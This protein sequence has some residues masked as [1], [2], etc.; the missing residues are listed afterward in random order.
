MARRYDKDRAATLMAY[1]GDDLGLRLGSVALRA[2][3]P[4]TYMAA[5][6]G[7][8][9]NSVGRWYMGGNVA[10]KHRA[11]AETLIQVFEGELRAGSD[12]PAR[13]LKAAREYLESLRGIG[14]YCSK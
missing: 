9:R 4:L 8:T 1:D 14:V 3:L 6:F 11:L 12:L 7:L 2:N 10:A 5:M 13:N